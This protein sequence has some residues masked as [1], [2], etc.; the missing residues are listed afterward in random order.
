MAKAKSKAIVMVADGAGGMVQVQDR[1]FESAGNWQVSFEVPREQADTWLRYFYEECARRGWSSGSINQLEA[2]ENSGSITVNTGGP[3]EPQLGVVWERKRG[4]SIKVRA[5]SPGTPAFPLAQLQELF[6]HVNERCRAGITARIY[7]RGLLYYNGL[8]WRGELWLDDT[9][10]L[11]PPELQFEDALL[12]P[13]VIL[14]DAL[15]ECVGQWDAA[16]AFDR[17]L[18]ELSAFLSVVMG[19]AVHTQ[20]SRQ[21]WT[22][23]RGEAGSAVRTIGYLGPEVSAQ[24]PTRGSAHPTPLKTVPRPN[25]SIGRGIDGSTNQVILP[26]DI[27]DL[28][29]RYRALTPELRRQFL[30]AAAKW[31]EAV[32]HGGRQ[33]TLSYALL[34]VACEALKPS[35]P[36]Y[37]DHNLYPV[38]EAL[39]GKENA[40]RLQEHWFR[41]QDVRNAHFHRGEF[42]ASEFVRDMLASSYLDPTFDHAHGELWRIAQAAIIEWLRRGGRFTM[43]T[44]ERKRT[45]RRWVKEH[46]FPIM[47]ILTSAGIA[48][49]LVLGWLLRML[50]YG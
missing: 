9:V 16:Y 40:D 21:V 28:W 45:F 25:L 10:R 30:Q 22:F 15:V 1:R 24:M 8:A 43:P 47:A 41:P 20:E 5:R 31:Q 48:A 6:A 7:C 49:G 3:G 34:V 36:L 18:Q 32:L 35:V 17:L 13:R 42:R 27:T 38:V 4:G 33:P 46:L 19:T 2:R 37:K 39:L 26:D 14:V 23:G 11:G 12:G 29:T 44:Q 50:W